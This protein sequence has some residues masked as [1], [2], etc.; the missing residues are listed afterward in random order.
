LTD[1]LIGTPSAYARR[2]EE[3][4]LLFN[5]MHH[6][7][8]AI[9]PS[10]AYATLEHVFTE[11]LKQKRERLRAV[12][13][14]AAAAERTLEKTPKESQMAVEEATERTEQASRGIVPMAVE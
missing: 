7:L 8:N 2:V 14:A 13:A 12:R 10:Q 9:R 6:L 1:D 4:T 5:N 11:Q 3:I